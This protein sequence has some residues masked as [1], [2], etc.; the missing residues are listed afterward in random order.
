MV[1]VARTWSDFKK[2]YKCLEVYGNS[3]VSRYGVR[4]E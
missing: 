1:E 4:G 2:F 3:D